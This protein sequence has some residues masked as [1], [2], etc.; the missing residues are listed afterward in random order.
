MRKKR[1][2]LT[3]I[4]AVAIVLVAY[5]AIFYS[6]SGS[7]KGSPEISLIESTDQYVKIQWKNSKDAK[8]YNIYRKED[9]G[10]FKKIVTL[11]GKNTE[12]ID[13]DVLVDNTYT[14]QIEEVLAHK[15]SKSDERKIS[16]KKIDAPELL[17]VK[18]YSTKDNKEAVELNWSSHDGYDYSVFRK[19]ADG[20]YQVIANV[21]ANSN[22]SSYIDSKIENTKDYTYTIRRK[23][24]D[25]NNVYQYGKF[26]E[27]GITTLSGKPEV[28]GDFTNLKATI[29]WSKVNGANNYIIY[30][31]QGLTGSYKQIAKVSGNK[32][33]YV[34]VYN[35]SLKTENEKKI[36]GA[37][38]FVDPSIND[39]VYTVRAYKNTNDKE[40]FSNYSKDGVFNICAPSIV[41][42]ENTKDNSTKVEWGTV[43]NANQYYVYSGYDDAQGE[44]HWEKLKTVDAKNSVVQSITVKPK[45]EHQYFTVKASFNRDGNNLYSD[46]DK[47]Y[48]INDRKYEN[49]NV[50]F[51][52]DS[53]TFGSPYKG[54]ATRTVF[55]YPWR[56]HQ[57]TNVNFYNPSIPGS[58][59][60]YKEKNNRS[61]MVQIADC[62]DKGKNV[63][64]ND[65]TKPEDMYVYKTDFVDNQIKGKKFKDFDV[66]IMAAGTNDYLDNNPFGSIHSTNIREFNGAINKVMS[67]VKKANVER[68]KE[69]K[70]AIKIVFVDLFYSDRTNNY[71]Q[72]T[73][74]F[75]TK[76]KIGLT[77]TDYQNDIN[78]LVKK[79]K[80][81][82]L[83]VYQFATDDLIN[84]KNCPYV[85]SDNLHMTR[86]AYGQIGNKLSDYLIKNK[87]I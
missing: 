20:K 53:I 54:K 18:R 65:L 79:Y 74:R 23:Q 80:Q 57:L 50:L 76:N 61:R 25:S 2:L 36:L 56:V 60:T 41:N 8:E 5:F 9:D 27:K 45:K 3:G 73:N 59:Y 32:T 11:D 47:N 22:K 43:K 4:L 17:S 1:I 34:D 33:Q 31:K 77:L 81:E 86:Y 52:G 48:R 38:Y 35:K 82:G 42:V 72:K 87:I 6:P 24:K 85:A 75:V 44:R 21:T 66:V 69:G 83:D 13:K 64:K 70:K 62:L 10:D 63:E 67:Y 28:K 71:A 12:Y 26:D 14:Y 29:S 58:T 55:S 19:E 15:T 16:L 51:F 39:L 49:K 84:Q 40:N 78:A 30:R 68:N 7:T 46:Y 37:G